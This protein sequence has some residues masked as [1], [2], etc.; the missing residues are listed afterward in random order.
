MSIHDRTDPLPT[1]RTRAMTSTPSTSTPSTSTASTSDQ[2]VS[3]RP[4]ATPSAATGDSRP[5]ASRRTSRA[6]WFSLGYI[7]YELRRNLRMFTTMFFIVVLPTFMYLIFGSMSSWGSYDLPSGR[8]NVAA[9]IM[10]SMAAY[11]AI[12]ATT[13]LSGS[14]AVELQQ[15]WGRQLALTPFTRGGYVLAKVVVAV[16]ISILPVVVVLVTG[17]LTSAHM[18][19]WVWLAAGLTTLFSSMVFSLYGLAFGL[20]FRSE[21]AVGAAT[22]GLVVFMFLGNAF[23]P[24]GGF[25]LDMSPWT[26][27]WGVMQLAQWPL[28]G[29]QTA[30]V[31]GNLLQYSLWQPIA[32][33]VVWGAVFGLMAYLASR[34]GTARA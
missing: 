25:L 19:G 8:G 23:A 18:D 4:A 31:D 3:S 20:T 26:P 16:A 14:A 30:D 24:L 15:G 6:T 17:A 28:T 11:G 29:G 21:S 22:G 34:R 10:I 13:S 32:N 27:V 1:T 5:G 7:G 2:S 9:S 12:T 33:V